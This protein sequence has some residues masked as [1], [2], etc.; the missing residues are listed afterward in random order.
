MLV[1]QT[2][3]V[4]TSFQ[5]FG[6]VLVQAATDV[7]AGKPWLTVIGGIG[8]GILTSLSQ[9]GELAPDLADKSHLFDTVALTLSAT[10]KVLLL[11]TASTLKV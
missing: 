1:D 6:N 11:G 2:V 5:A 8:S 4:E 9:V 7:K 10:A 3:K